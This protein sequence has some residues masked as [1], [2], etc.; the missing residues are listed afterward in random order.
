MN[1]QQ[2]RLPADSSGCRRS[3]HRSLPFRVESGSRF[4]YNSN[5]FSDQYSLCMMRCVRT[6][7]VVPAGSASFDSGMMWGNSLS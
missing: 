1:I 2:L 4:R 5:P 6:A 7:R 3:H